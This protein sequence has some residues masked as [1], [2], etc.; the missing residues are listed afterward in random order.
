MSKIFNISGACRPDRHY[1]VNLGAKLEKIKAMID[2]GQYFTINK[3]RQYGKTP[4]LRAFR[5]SGK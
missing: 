1:M 2:N 4:P 5:L 3:A